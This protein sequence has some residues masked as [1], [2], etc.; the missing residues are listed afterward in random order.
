MVDTAVSHALNARVYVALFAIAVFVTG[1]FLYSDWATQEPILT[2]DAAYWQRV[3]ED[4][5]PKAAR[6]R[7]LSST[8]YFSGGRKHVA[9]H[10]FSRAL[11]NVY[12]AAALGYCGSEYVGGCIHEVSA[13]IFLNSPDPTDFVAECTAKH[14]SED[15]IDRAC[16][17][18]LGHALMWREGYTREGI[19]RAM[20]GCD[21][22]GLSALSISCSYGVIMEWYFRYIGGNPDI[23]PSDAAALALCQEFSGP[24]RDA[25]FFNISTVW[26]TLYDPTRTT[27]RESV[28]R[29]GEA[30]RALTNVERDKH[31]CVLGA[32]R[33]I[34]LRGQYSR[35]ER[36]EACDAAFPDERDAAT[37][38]SN[39][40][41][42]LSL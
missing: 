42:A 4:K 9:A 15:F 30:C 31:Y 8:E 35:Y 34:G 25:C 29:V 21:D 20:Q 16:V 17:H 33:L 23:Y 22:M 40:E 1:I 13:Q 5:G 3:I 6:V 11:Y 28:I 10:A 2:E 37:C 19:H 24:A 18:G 36:L 27:S 26:I 32:G 7:Y 39:V 41:Y 12:G 14:A 38:K